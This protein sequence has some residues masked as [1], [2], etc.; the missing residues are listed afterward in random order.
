MLIEHSFVTT[1]PSQQALGAAS[2][3]LARGGFI[4]ENQ[5]GFRVG[6]TEWTTLQ[7]KR[8]KKRAARA[9]DPSECPQ[10]IRMEWDRGR[11]TVA[12]AIE[13]KSRR[14]GYYY[15]GGLIG[16]AVVAATRSRRGA[17]KDAKD[18]ADLMILIT[19]SLED[20]LARG[21]LPEVAQQPW[22]A[23][24]DVLKA[25]AKKARMKLLILFGV[26]FAIIICFAVFAGVTSTN[27]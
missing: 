21:A 24:Q 18:Y 3:M 7:M 2:E 1:L 8:G 12:A 25:K 17:G 15:G 20:L 6:E 16:V 10:R 27:R 5:E 22:Y 4:A 26:L 19:T 11:V 23:F 14:G 13:P 9:K